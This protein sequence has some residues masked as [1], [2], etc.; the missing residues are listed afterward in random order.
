MAESVGFVSLGCAKNLVNTEQMIFLLREAGYS[1]S[2]VPDQVD[3]AVINTCGFIEAAKSEAIEQ[4]LLA[5]QSKAEGRVGK[6]LVTGC[7]SQR[8]RD[9]IMEEIPEIDGVLGAPGRAGLH[10]RRYRRALGGAGTGADYAALV[11]LSAHC[12]GV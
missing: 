1:I 9:E 10:V 6:L 2:E 4:I 5:A 11:R 7:L 8:Y 12:R 3:L